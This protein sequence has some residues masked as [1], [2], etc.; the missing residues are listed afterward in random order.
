[1]D[2]LSTSPFSVHWIG[3]VS[4]SCPWDEPIARII[5]RRPR[6]AG[7]GMNGHL[8]AS[9]GVVDQH[10]LA[11]LP[12]RDP[13]PSRKLPSPRRRLNPCPGCLLPATVQQVS[14]LHSMAAEGSTSILLISGSCSPLPNLSIPIPQAPLPSPPT[15]SLL[16][17]ASSQRS[18]TMSPR[19]TRWQPREAPPSS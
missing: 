9:R 8:E 18:S 2:S 16:S 17:G 10:L 13:S 7:G 15:E 3:H 11:S 14:S 5:A 19:S 1:M 12:N 4:Q 6:L